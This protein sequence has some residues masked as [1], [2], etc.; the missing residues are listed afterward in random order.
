MNKQE[1]LARLNEGLYGLPKEE[2]EERLSFYS[3]MI[4]DGMEEGLSEEEAVASLGPIGD[5]VSQTVAQTPF[6]KLVKEK[7]KNKRPI[8]A[9]ETVLLILGSPIWL[10]LLI[11]AAAIALSLYAVLFALIIALW[12]I[13]L[14][15]AVSAVASAAAGFAELFKGEYYQ[16]LVLIGTGLALA[17]IAIFLFFGCLAA[18]R[19]AIRLNGKIAL[20]IKS[21]FVGK[22]KTK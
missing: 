17:G 16:G 21:L 1:F 13:D 11:A 15:L 18:T 19:G 2:L 9:W 20:W 6:K 4:D 7:V 22:E 10:P 12:A 5:M 8:K 14:A 3:E